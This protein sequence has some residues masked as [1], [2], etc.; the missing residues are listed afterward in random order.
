[1]PA[2]DTADLLL[3]TEAVRQAGDIAR[4]YFGGTYRSWDKSKGQPVTDADLAVDRYLRDTLMA[5]RP[6][7]GWLSEES[8]ED[9]ARR[10]ARRTFVVDP[11]DGTVAFLRGKPHFTISVAVVEDG[12]PV[13]AA[14][15]NPVLD[16]S[17]AAA[18]GAG[19]TLNGAAIAA[20]RRT[21][22]AGCRMLAP[23]S[24][25][26]HHIWSEPPNRPWPAMQ[27][28]QRNSIAY[29]LALIAADR[30]DAMI[31]LS[32]KHD[33]DMAAA[34]LILHEAGGLLTDHKGN[35]LRYNG[36]QSIQR[37]LA[38]SGGPL[39]GALLAQLQHLS[40]P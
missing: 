30:F 37:S 12:R 13:A 35:I 14:V 34:D 22:L 16:E 27:I 23:K 32:A 3:L 33:W 40:I 1:L 29:R 9:T 15:L 8:A 26:E 21:T 11:I 28:D 18:K 25:F 20:G 39:H 4:S 24:L 38:G 2:P 5:A 31:A 6:A 10:S 19:A 36:P 7:Y 17:F